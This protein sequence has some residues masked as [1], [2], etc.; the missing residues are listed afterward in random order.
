MFAR[1]VLHLA[2]CIVNAS[3]RTQTNAELKERGTALGRVARTFRA[4]ACAFHESEFSA[5]FT[6]RLN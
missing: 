3:R 6:M 5:R 4:D 1:T 2:A